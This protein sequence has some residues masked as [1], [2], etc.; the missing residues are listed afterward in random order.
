MRRGTE[1]GMGG[2]TVNGQDG[3]VC[4]VADRSAWDLEEKQFE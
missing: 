2:G 4:G 1:E 3:V